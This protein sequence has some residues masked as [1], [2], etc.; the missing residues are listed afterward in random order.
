MSNRL[1]IK[2]FYQQIAFDYNIK[3][4]GNY[5]THVGSIF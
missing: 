4:S 1:R 2:I 3:L 5:L